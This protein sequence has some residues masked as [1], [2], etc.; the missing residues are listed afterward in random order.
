MRTEEQIAEAHANSKESMILKLVSEGTHPH[1]AEEMI[2]L[3]H[4]HH[5]YIC[6]ELD[7]NP[8][9]GLPFKQ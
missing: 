8:E 7:L 6:M 9:T 1:V 4:W 5:R 2:Q 3:N